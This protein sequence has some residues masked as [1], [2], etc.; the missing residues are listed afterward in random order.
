MERTNKKE[1]MDGPKVYDVKNQRN[2]ASF[3]KTKLNAGNSSKTEQY[4]KA[5]NC[6]LSDFQSD[7]NSF[8]EL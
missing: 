7:I 4:L 3:S 5:I 6:F 2:I 1:I 8:L